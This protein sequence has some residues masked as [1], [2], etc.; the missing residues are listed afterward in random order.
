MVDSIEQL[1]GI[2][3]NSTRLFDLS[4]DDEKQLNEIADIFQEIGQCL[5]SLHQIRVNEATTCFQIPASLTHSSAAGRPEYDIPKSVLE[6]LRG[7]CFSWS[8]IASM[9]NVS[10]WTV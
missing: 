10:A 4:S 7:L 9:L 5:L 2:F 8:K 1:V 3:H 6:E